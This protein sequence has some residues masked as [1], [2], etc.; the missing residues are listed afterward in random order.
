MKIS[1]TIGNIKR[2]NE[3]ITVLSKNGFDDIVKKINFEGSIKLPVFNYINKDNLSK[4]QRVKKTVAIIIASTLIGSSLLLHAKTP[5]LIFGI[6]LFGIAGFSVASV[7]G[8]I[9]AYF[10]YKGGKL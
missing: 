1:Q 5:P 2:V 6:P 8:L 4:S 7:M 3:I 10:I 9:L